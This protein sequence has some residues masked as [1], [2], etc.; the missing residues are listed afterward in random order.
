MLNVAE[1][2]FSDVEDISGSELMPHG[3]VALFKVKEVGQV[4]PNSNGKKF[5]TVTFEVAEGPFAGKEIKENYY[6]EGKDFALQKTRIFV[7]YVLETSI[8]A[9]K[10]SK[11]AYKIA[12]YK[13][14]ETGKVIAKVKVK[15]FYGD[16]GDWI[17]ANEI[18]AL[19][20]PREDSSTFKIYQAYKNGEQLWQSDYKPAPAPRSGGVAQ[21]YSDARE[22]PPVS[23]Y[24]GY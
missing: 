15:G 18:D 22:S 5:F 9:H 3:T 10:K 1:T 17:Y 16:S 20:T 7:R 11:E 4:R 13:S 6:L 23:A 19:A 12:S 21:G 8:D 24:E 2:D 14:L